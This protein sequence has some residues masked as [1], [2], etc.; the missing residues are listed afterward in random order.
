MISTTGQSAKSSVPVILASLLC[1]MNC[2]NY[3]ISVIPQKFVPFHM[4]PE[5]QA[6]KLQDTG[7]LHYNL[8]AV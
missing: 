4:G 1:P 3:A 5:A 8:F 7:D 6:Y 2:I